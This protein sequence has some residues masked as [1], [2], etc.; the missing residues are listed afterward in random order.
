MSRHILKEGNQGTSKYKHQV[1]LKRTRSVKLK[2]SCSLTWIIKRAIGVPGQP[3]KTSL[4][5][6]TA[7]TVPPNVPGIYVQ[8][9]I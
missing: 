1:Y 4:T 5:S 6:S 3:L 2:L 7:L 9:Y 8:I